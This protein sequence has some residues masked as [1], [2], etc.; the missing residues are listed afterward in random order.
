MERKKVI[1]HYN[2]LA[3]EVIE[4]LRTKYPDGYQ[5]H[6]KK[7][8]KPSNDFFYAVAL[9]TEDASYLIKVDVKID[10]ISENKLDDAIFS[11]IDSTKT[12]GKIPDDELESDDSEDTGDSDSDKD[13]D[14]DVF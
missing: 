12:I 4:A 14:D 7:I 11:G 8:T 5:H 3:P 2:N 13:K 9:D 6:V 1:I 10:N